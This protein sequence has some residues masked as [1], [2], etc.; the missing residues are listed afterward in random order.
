MRTLLLA[1]TA[2]IGV[3]GANANPA[4]PVPPTPAGRYL[5][6]TCI[7]T[8]GV[9]NGRGHETWTLGFD[10]VD[11]HAEFWQD[12]K[13]ETAR[14]GYYTP[15]KTTLTGLV[16][17]PKT[18]MNLAMID[19][20]GDA[21]L[22]WVERGKSGTM[23]CRFPNISNV[24]PAVWHDAATAPAA[25]PAA[26]PIASPPAT[27]AQLNSVPVTFDNQG[28]NVAVS[29]G[30]MPV[31]MVVDTGAIGMT[32]TETVANWL[33]S[34]GHAT[35]GA[36]DKHTLAG[37]EEKEFKSVDIDTLNIAGHELH[38][39]HAGVVPDGAGMLLGLPILAQLTNKIAIDFTN[40]K[41]TFN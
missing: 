15:A 2:L 26:S 4:T 19:L 27:A 11:G 40:A 41:L 23:E 31:T 21:R 18:P 8:N 24:R 36:S 32:V 10:N 7:A 16:G 38:K 33:I 37:G 34:N 12:D 39:V 30:S 13:P 20:G 29:L 35:N 25:Q 9:E 17:D 3:S 6:L 14:W 1:A 5:L 22:T 28:A